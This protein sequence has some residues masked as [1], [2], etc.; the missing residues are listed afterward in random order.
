MGAL[1]TLDGALRDALTR[2]LDSHSQRLDAIQSII[3]RP[4]AILAKQRLRLAG[5]AQKIRFAGRDVLASFE[6]ELQAMALSLPVQTRQH[7]GQSAQRLD[8]A[9]LRLDLLDPRLVLARGYAWVS[10]SDGKTVTR[11]RDVNTADAIHVQLAEGQ[12]QALVTEV[13]SA[14]SIKKG[15]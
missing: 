1:T 10:T 14:D 2:R 5:N 12:L 4:S 9:A 7:M 13:Q 11:A 6:R 8:R 3:S 15:R